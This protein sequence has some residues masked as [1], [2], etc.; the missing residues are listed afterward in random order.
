M[1]TARQQLGQRSE[2]LA[3]LRLRSE[4]YRIDQINV[5]FPV[6]EIDVIAWE[7]ETLCFV[8]VRS[9]TSDDWGGPLAS[10]TGKK[11]HRLVQAARWYLQRLPTMPRYMRF[12]V[13]AIQWC[14]GAP[15]VQLIRDAFDAS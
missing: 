2:Q 14:E 9:T 7:G 1:R 13:V 8:E 5:R 10:I 11:R 4:G 15:S 3:K 6:G 12:D